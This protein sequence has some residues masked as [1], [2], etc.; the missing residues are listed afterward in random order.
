MRK[1]QA[2]KLADRLQELAKGGGHRDDAA[3]QEIES[4]TSE[5][6]WENIPG[7]GELL[8]KI[9]NNGGI[10]FSPRKH[11]RVGGAEAVRRWM[12][13]DIMSLRDA[14]KAADLPTE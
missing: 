9:R 12:R 5:L 4:I 14:I 10:L 8:G 1:E 2:L 7:T 11:V 3:L 13:H 6:E